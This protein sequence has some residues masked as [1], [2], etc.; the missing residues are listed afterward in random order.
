MDP[1]MIVRRQ[2]IAEGDPSAVRRP[3]DLS[4]VGL[5]RYSGGAQFSF[6]AA[7]RW[8]NVN[9]RVSAS[10]AMK[11]DL[12]AVGGPSRTDPFRGM[13]RKAEKSLAPDGLYI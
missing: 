11:R 7:K 9:A 8:D 12:R 1:R 5:P 6:G 2:P 10:Q 3:T 4:W 13:L